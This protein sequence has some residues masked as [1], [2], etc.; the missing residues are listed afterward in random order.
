[1]ARGKQQQPKKDGQHR[2]ETKEEKRVRLLREKEAKEVSDY[3]LV[4]DKK[5]CLL[6]FRLQLYL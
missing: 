2:P 6:T 5:I 1:M 4:F 3:K